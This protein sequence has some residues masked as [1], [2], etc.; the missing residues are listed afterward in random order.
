MNK[1]HFVPAQPGYR[2]WITFEETGKRYASFAGEVVAWRVAYTDDPTGD[3]AACVAVAVLISG[4]EAAVVE[5]DGFLQ[6]ENYSWPSFENWLRDADAVVCCADA[7]R[8]RAWYGLTDELLE[9]DRAAR[10]SS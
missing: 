6:H 2:A 7:A 3:R 10:V 4:D 5:R 9:H 8:A 1:E